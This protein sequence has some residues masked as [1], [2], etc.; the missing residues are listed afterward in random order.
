M[1]VPG[2]LIVSFPEWLSQLFEIIEK[3]LSYAEHL[4]FAELLLIA[5]LGVVG[6]LSSNTRFIR[7][8]LY[9]ES[10]S[11]YFRA[12]G[13]ACWIAKNKISKAISFKMARRLV[14]I[15]ILNPLAE[16]PVRYDFESKEKFD[17]ALKEWKEDRERH[18]Q[19]ITSTF[20]RITRTSHAEP[21]ESSDGPTEFPI[22][23]D[24][25]KKSVDQCSREIR[26]YF[27]VLNDLRSKYDAP[28]KS[29]EFLS[30]VKFEGGYVGPQFLVHGLLSRFQEDWKKV[31]DN[32]DGQVH[33]SDKHYSHEL[34]ELRA[35]Q[36]SCWL[37]WGPSIPICRCD[38][39]HG[40]S[41]IDDQLRIAY[42]YGYGDEDNSIDLLTRIDNKKVVDS[43]SNLLN[44]I[45][46]VDEQN[47][48]RAAPYSL[49]GRIKWGPNYPKALIC[50]A[51]KAIL[52]QEEARQWGRPV[53][54]MLS[55]KHA[56]RQ[57]TGIKTKPEKQSHYFSAYIWVMFVITDKNGVPL[58]SN[59]KWRNFLPYFEH[60]NI[61]D[62]ST[63]FVQKHMLIAKVCLGLQRI[64][65]QN[66]DIVIA[67]ACTS[68][69]SMCQHSEGVMYQPIKR[70]ELLGQMLRSSIET[71]DLLNNLLADKRIILPR[72][73]DVRGDSRLE[74]Y[75]SCKL[76]Q[77]LEEFFCSLVSPEPVK[78]IIV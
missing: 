9:P 32:Y 72:K 3:F 76:P 65:E 31:I 13:K 56:T 53:L 8:C 14:E 74:E 7:K 42:Q 46:V 6:A 75:S 52:G 19:E 77:R 57:N 50:D 66:Q 11:G 35:T 21:N 33:A 78:K 44:P 71:N 16:R 4:H 49:I 67:L 62:A 48:V 51:Q 64:L 23:F 34:V 5:V 63:Y 30:T 36:F 37:Q 45:M 1:Q 69:Q 22:T 29:C 55:A 41:S 39:W 25:T 43:L 20:R 47:H 38:C 15:E 60:G 40:T 54:E 10:P 17:A 61:A 26:R 58:Y 12:F 27:E 68:D 59:E 24:I 28:P 18:K 70:N 2:S 73:G